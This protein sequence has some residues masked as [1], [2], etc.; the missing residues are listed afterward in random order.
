MKFSDFLH[1]NIRKN[2]PP[3]WQLE[4]E[5]EMNAHKEDAKDDL[6]KQGY[7][8]ENISSLI[9]TQF[10]D[11][12]KAWVEL[13][14]IHRF[15]SLPKLFWLGLYGYIFWTSVIHLSL[16][17]VFNY[18]LKPRLEDVVAGVTFLP[19][20]FGFLSFMALFSPFTWAFLG[21]SGFLYLF[22]LRLTKQKEKA[23]FIH[24]VANIGL[25]LSLFLTYKD[26]NVARVPHAG[27]PFQA[28]QFP[29]NG[30]DMPPVE[31][32]PL[33]FL[34]MLCWIVAVYACSFLYKHIPSYAKTATAISSVLITMAGIAYV[35]IQFD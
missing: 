21:V 34:N 9:E 33:F 3:K 16:W 7:K 8:E 5:R 32:W 10:G 13:K 25:W 22:L 20:F 23:M 19:A 6:L 28:L 11:E 1:K 26:A 15:D 17:P 31:Q 27:F 24:A 30:G 12:K 14:R 35:L 29:P 4:V 18:G 2:H